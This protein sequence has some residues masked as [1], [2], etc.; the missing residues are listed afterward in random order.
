MS[1]QRRGE[2]TYLALDLPEHAVL[3]L[4]VRERVGEELVACNDTHTG[5]HTHR[6]A[7]T[8]GQKI[9]ARFSGIRRRHE[10]IR[11]RIYPSE[12]RKNTIFRPQIRPW[13]LPSSYSSP[14]PSPAPEGGKKKK[15]KNKSGHKN[16]AAHAPV[17][18]SW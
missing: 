16:K 2:Q 15:G 13:R 3:D 10:Q 18:R 9:T 1:G 17:S 12:P 4:L 6:L 14:N 11:A 7:N 5:K 8:R